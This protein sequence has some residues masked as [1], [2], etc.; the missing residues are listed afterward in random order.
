MIIPPLSKDEDVFSDYFIIDPKVLIENNCSF[1]MTAEE[2]ANIEDEGFL[3]N[4]KR[5]LLYG[6]KNKII[7]RRKAYHKEWA[8]QSRFIIG[9]DGGEE[10][11]YICIN[12]LSCQVFTYELETKKVVSKI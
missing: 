6:A 10:Y 3:G 8:G 1:E 12:N 9:N 4:I 2:A 11:Y 7:E 5:F